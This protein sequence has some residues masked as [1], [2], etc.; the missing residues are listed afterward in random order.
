MTFYDRILMHSFN[1]NVTR[2]IVVEYVF[3][4][5]PNVLPHAFINQIK[6]VESNSPI[7][8]SSPKRSPFHKQFHDF[9]GDPCVSII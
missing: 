1:F 9:C 6:S 3:L 5:F 4:F 2:N 7:I 8:P